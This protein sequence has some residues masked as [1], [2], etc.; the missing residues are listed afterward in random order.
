MQ[1]VDAHLARPWDRRP[2]PPDVVECLGSGRS[3][4]RGPWKR[5]VI[6]RGSPADILVRYLEQEGVGHLFGV[7]G[8]HL[9][10]LYDAV[11]RSGR[12]KAVLAKNEQGAGYMANGYARVSGRLGVCCGTVG[13][14]ATNLV[15][16]VATA[17]MDSVPVLVLTAQVG[18]TAIGK[19]A[20]QEGAGDG[21]TV[22]HVGIFRPITKHS[23]MVTRSVLVP[24]AVRKAI[25]IAASGR[26]GPGPPGPA[27]GRA[28]GRGRGP[29]P[30]ARAL[31]ACQSRR[32][33]PGLRRVGR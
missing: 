27:I 24:E 33:R 1:L 16:G 11:H 26:P 2:G 20:L 6:V 19:G 9:L 28:E 10:A 15:S 7:P 13:P 32:G 21:R 31:P 23:A 3:S 30:V 12:V 29:D 18:T 5:G 17:Y 8:G 4:L 22:D 14:G 25:R